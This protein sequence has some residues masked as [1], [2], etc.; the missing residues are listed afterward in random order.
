MER[1]VIRVCRAGN[2]TAPLH[3]G[4]NVLLE[5]MSARRLVAESR[6]ARCRSDLRVFYAIYAVVVIGLFW[7]SSG[8]TFAIELVLK[9]MVALWCVG[10]IAVLLTWRWFRG[11][12]LAALAPLISALSIQSG[13]RI[14]F[15]FEHGGMD[16]GT[17][18]GSPLAFLLG[19][20]I[21]IALLIP[22]VFLWIW[23]LR[24]RRQDLPL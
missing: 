12:A 2:E 20:I 11:V 19:W 13:R 9:A 24:G 18:Y 8:D 17:C 7:V 15:I 10:L 3:A 6:T 21:E 1:S 5:V 4:Y 14:A 22:G 16:C 23:L